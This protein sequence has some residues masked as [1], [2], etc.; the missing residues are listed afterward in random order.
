MMIQKHESKSIRI[1]GD[2][3]IQRKL[4][5]EKEPEMCFKGNCPRR[6]LGGLSRSE[7]VSRDRKIMS[8]S[9][10]EDSFVYIEHLR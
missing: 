5:Y 4:H 8:R 2:H 3:Q 9:F 1:V 7:E 6:S 10:C